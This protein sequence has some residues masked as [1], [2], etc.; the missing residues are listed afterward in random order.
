MNNGYSHSLYDKEPKPHKYNEVCEC[1]ECIKERRRLYVEAKREREEKERA[2]AYERWKS[3][4]ER[5]RELETS[6]WYLIKKAHPDSDLLLFLMY[7]FVGFIVG[8]ANFPG[9]GGFSGFFFGGLIGVAL[10]SK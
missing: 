3:D 1:S 5:Q 9:L 4:Q 8:E 2:E 7:G 6:L 10:F